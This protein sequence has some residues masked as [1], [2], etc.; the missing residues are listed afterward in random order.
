MSAPAPITDHALRVRHLGR[1]AYTEAWHAMRG[2][3]DAR[4]PTTADELWV[5]EHPPVYTLGWNAHEAHVLDPG[6][7][8]VV[9]CDRGGQV[10]YHGPGQLVVYT[11]V[12]LA[13][14]RLG[15]R[16]FVHLLEQAV[17]DLLA[18]Y[19]IRGERR[20]GAPGVYVGG[21]KLA[22]LG[23]RVRRGAAYHGLSLNVAMDLAPFRRI[24]PC[25]FAGLPITQLRDL[26]GPDDPARVAATLLAALDTALRT[27]ESDR[28]PDAGAPTS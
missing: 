1:V 21:A 24:D 20:D 3:T 25:G 16:A 9:R 27:P 22:A 4:S 5:L 11:L 26:G 23:L 6:E 8:P 13:R 15:V 10:T 7:I 19:G 17:L 28:P 12:D 2:F 18:G 14:R